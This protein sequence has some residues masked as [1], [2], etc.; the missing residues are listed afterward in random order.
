LARQ[1]LQ[2]WIACCAGFAVYGIGRLHWI[3]YS[4]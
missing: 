4:L 1:E 2:F 3:Q